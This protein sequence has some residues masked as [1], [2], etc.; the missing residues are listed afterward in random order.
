[1]PAHGEWLMFEDVEVEM[2]VSSWVESQW[3]FNNVRKRKRK[4]LCTTI[5]SK[6]FSKNSL[7]LL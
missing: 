5:E 4:M 7:T 6:H 3:G 2:K 1:M